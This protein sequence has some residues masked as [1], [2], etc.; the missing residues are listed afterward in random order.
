M[1]DGCAPADTLM[2]GNVPQAH[3]GECEHKAA[4]RCCREHKRQEEAVVSLQTV[5]L[6]VRMLLV[7]EKQ[8][9]PDCNSELQSM[10]YATG[11]LQIGLSAP[12]AAGS[13]IFER[14]QQV[15][16][17]MGDLKHHCKHDRDQCF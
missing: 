17:W 12:T 1:P 16:A 11:I 10:P 2:V 6:P 7:R 15:Q 3:K 14:C 4:E 13:A 5:P 8:T 9:Q